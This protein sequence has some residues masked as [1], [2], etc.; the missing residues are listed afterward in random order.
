MCVQCVCVLHPH[1][2]LPTEKEGC[3]LFFTDTVCVAWPESISACRL[4][5]HTQYTARH[6]ST[7]VH[8]TGNTTHA[9][10]STRLVRV[11]LT[12]A[13]THFISLQ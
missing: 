11:E 10:G 3:W 8:I 13:V 12:A 7:R 9:C 4:H 1:V 5:P 6:K 2:E